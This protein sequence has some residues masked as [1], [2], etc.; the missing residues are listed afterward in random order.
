MFAPANFNQNAQEYLRHANDNI[1]VIVQIES[2]K[3]VENCEEIAQ[4]EGIGMSLC[5][6]L[7]RRLRIRISADLL[8]GNIVT[9]YALHWSQ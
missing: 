7:F 8:M 4:T 3:A 5:V 1:L 6:E 2:R 9:R